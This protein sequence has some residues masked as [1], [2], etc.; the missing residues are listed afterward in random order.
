MRIEK[1]G[2]YRTKNGKKV[3][4]VAV[5]D[6]YAIGFCKIGPLSWCDDGRHW[7]RETGANGSDQNLAIVA[8][9]RDPAIETVVLELCI[10]DAGT[11]FTRFAYNHPGPV[12]IIAR[13]TI[14]ITEGEG[15]STS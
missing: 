15:M 4:V 2:F 3:E 11:R 6:G 1:P 12:T 13:K 14:T 8:E 7:N 5:R 10:S 9:W